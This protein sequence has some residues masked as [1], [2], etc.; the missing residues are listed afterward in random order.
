MADSPGARILKSWVDL[1]A[2][3]RG[4]L[5][6]CSVAPPT[7]PSELLAALRINHSLGPDEEALVR[8]LREIRT[9]VAHSGQEP[10]EAEAA[11]FEEAVEGIKLRLRQ[12]A[13]GTC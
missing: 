7:Q 3:L 4:A 11:E 13:L 5:P 2:A 6:V 10:P 1:E 9:R 12:G 8:S